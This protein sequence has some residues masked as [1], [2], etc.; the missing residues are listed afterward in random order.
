VLHPAPGAT[1][2]VGFGGAGMT[3]SFVATEEALNTR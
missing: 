3:L 1:A 2:I